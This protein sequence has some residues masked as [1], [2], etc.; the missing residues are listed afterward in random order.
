MEPGS[1]IL[2]IH[3]TKVHDVE[4]AIR[5]SRIYHSYGNNV[6]MAVQ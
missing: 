6:K 2:C 4:V 5:N 3:N 1:C